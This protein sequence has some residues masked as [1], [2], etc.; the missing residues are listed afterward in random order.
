MHK[1]INDKIRIRLLHTG[2]DTDTYYTE[3]LYGFACQHYNDPHVLFKLKIKGYYQ[4]LYK[5]SDDET[6]W[7]IENNLEESVKW[8]DGTQDYYIDQAERFNALGFNSFTNWTCNAG[9][10]SVII[11]GTE[12]KRAYSCKETNI[13]NILTGFEL[14]KEPKICIT[15]RC[16]SSADSKVPKCK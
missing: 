13:G 1:A 2:N 6:E 9:Y 4:K 3:S 8:S 5:W 15:P 10:Q 12:V 16:V 14:F 7:F 11:K